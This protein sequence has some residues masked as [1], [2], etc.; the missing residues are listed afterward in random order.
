MDTRGDSG[1]DAQDADR[2]SLISHFLES[3]KKNP[4]FLHRVQ[5]EDARSAFQDELHLHASGFL[6]PLIAF[7]GEFGNYVTTVPKPDS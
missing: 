6:A 5:L 2:V 1:L 4:N 3:V 7:I